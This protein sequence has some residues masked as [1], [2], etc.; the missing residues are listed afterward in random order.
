MQPENRY[1]EIMF[2]H[3]AATDWGIFQAWAAREG[4]RVPQREISLYRQELADSVFVSRD[5]DGTPL[6]FITVCRHQRQAWIGNLIVDPDRRGAGHGRALFRHAVRLLEERGV[7]TLWLTASQDGLPL[8]AGCGFHEVSKVERW[9]WQSEGMGQ[10]QEETQGNGELFTLVRA[11]ATAWGTSRAEVL[12][13][14][15]RGGKVFV[16]GSSVALLQ[17]GQDLSVL[18]P[19]VSSDCCPRSN[20]AILAKVMDAH[21]GREIALDVPERSP[22]RL[23][24]SAAGFQKAG[25]TRLMMRGDRSSARLS[26]IMSLAS[27]GSMG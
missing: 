11:D 8:Y 19:W 27:L 20:R 3:P 12:S 9:V 6:G 4:W 24:L 14:L 7:T 23:L 21:R 5:C 25:E 26:E 13:L 16:S 22:V 1:H 15:A 17:V 10:N 18:G 2:N